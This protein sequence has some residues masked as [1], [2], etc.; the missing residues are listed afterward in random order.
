MSRMRAHCSRH[1]E[2][3]GSRH[4][5]ADEH[6]FQVIQ[7]AHALQLCAIC[8]TCYT[9]CLRGPCTWFWFTPA[10]ITTQIMET[11][12]HT[13]IYPPSA[14]LQHVNSLVIPANQDAYTSEY[15]CGRRCTFGPLGGLSGK[16]VNI[17]AYTFHGH[18]FMT[19]MA[20]QSCTSW[21]QLWFMAISRT[22]I[23]CKMYWQSH[24]GSAW[25]AVLTCFV[26]RWLSA[27]WLHHALLRVSAVFLQA[28]AWASGAAP[29]TVFLM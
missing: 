7:A 8:A 15:S 11:A 24:R 16:P 14:L 22:C 21:F 12:D 17:A 10:G 27:A 9:A 19:G 6:A 1:M 18:M 2:A 28:C 20:A 23:L 5:V 3:L 26:W 29:C 13:A 25:F 4:T